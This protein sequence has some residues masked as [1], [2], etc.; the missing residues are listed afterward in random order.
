VENGFLVGGKTRKDLGLKQGKL[1]HHAR[2]GP[3][4]KGGGSFQKK[5]GGPA[6]PATR[7]DAVELEGGHHF[8][9]SLKR[10]KMVHTPPT[11]PKD[12]VVRRKG[13]KKKGEWASK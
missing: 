9:H 13:E 5:R 7:R 3:R 1:K 6:K 4:R 11:G 2:H 12:A 10:K 8:R